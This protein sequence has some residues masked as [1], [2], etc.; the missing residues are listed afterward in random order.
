MIN[1]LFRILVIFLI[2]CFAFTA[3][4]E[5]FTVTSAADSGP[6]TLRDAILKSNAN[7]TGEK[8]FIY[9]NLPN[10]SWNERSI[11]VN[12]HLP[13]IRGGNLVIDGTTQPGTKLG[14]SDAK[15]IIQRS[16]VVDPNDSRYFALRLRQ[17]ND[18]EIYGIALIYDDTPATLNGYAITLEDVRRI[19]IGAPGKGNLI[20]GFMSGITN[21]TTFAE[22]ITIQGNMAGVMEDGISG[23]RCSIELQN[24]N[25]I[26]LGGTGAGEG[27]HLGMTNVMFAT[28]GGSMIIKG[29][30]MGVTHSGDR[31]IDACNLSLSG[32]AAETILT[33]NHI[34]NGGI[35]LYNL[36]HAF[37]VRHNKIGTDASGTQQL[38][39]GPKY[40]GIRVASCKEGSI[41]ENIITGYIFAGVN[42]SES[43][44]V[45]VSRNEM[46]CNQTGIFLTWY[47]DQAGRPK[48]FADIV[49]CDAG[50]TYGIATPNSKLEIFEPDYCGWI[51]GG[52]TCQGRKYLATITVDA[53]GKWLYPSPPAKGIIVTAT[54]Q[55]G[56]T[57]EYSLA[58]IDY[59]EGYKVVQPTCGMANGSIKMKV[60]RGIIIGWKDKDGKLISTDTSLYNLSPADYTFYISSSGCSNETCINGYWFRLEDI[61]PAIDSRNVIITNASCNH[62]NGEITNLSFNGATENTSY[63]WR[64]EQGEIVG[65]GQGLTARPGKYTL[66]MS[67]KEGSCIATSGPFEIKNT[68]GPYMDLNSVIITNASCGKANGSISGIQVHATGAINYKWVNRE[69]VIVSST[70][71]LQGISAG[72]YLLKYSD[73]SGCPEAETDSFTISDQGAITISTMH[74]T[75]TPAGCT[76]G[77]GAIKGIETTGATSF[78]WLNESGQSAGN[79]PD[80]SNAAPGKYRLLLENMDGCSASTDFIEIKRQQPVALQIQ[81]MTTSPAYCNEDNGAIS[82]LSITGGTP[83]SY[84]WMNENNQLA[85]ILERPT[86]LA[87]GAYQLYVTD[88]NGCEKYLLTAAITKVPPPAIISRNQKITPDEC[89]F[90]TGAISGIT[91]TGEAPFNYTWYSNNTIKGQHLALTG[92]TAGEY[93]LQVTDKYGCKVQSSG[94][95]VNNID[96]PL[97]APFPQSVSIVKGMPATIAVAVPQTGTYYLYSQPGSSPLQSNT[98]GIFHIENITKNTSFYISLQSGSCISP[99]AE[100]PVKV[101]DE[102]KIIAPNAFSPNNDGTNDRFRIRALGLARLEYFAVYNRWGAP[103]FS[104]TNPEA[105]WDGQLNNTPQPAGTYVWIVKGKDIL[106]EN[107]QYSGHVLLIR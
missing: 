19:K 76:V 86:G 55:G 53:A 63:S 5:T 59:E 58:E 44:A 8:D 70:L 97:Q 6:G 69:G 61:T 20:Y 38:Q 21:G 92:I 11:S 84:R 100:V 60:K 71:D 99:L 79:T 54:D 35:Y 7:G 46:F 9:F 105:G 12:S 89:N 28:T 78:K 57:S 40:T 42:L 48:P 75:V 82:E 52:I 41:T 32:N 24:I 2:L 96:V 64:N 27:N 65:D 88:I 106:G 51:D 15:V 37:T 93:Y 3:D 47:E 90:S 25:G 68:T 102:I 39:T 72:K 49:H 18:V 62:N 66:T 29:N 91:V 33:D 22:N 107:V 43:Y 30:K 80:L 56:A 31:E 94:Y 87:P 67:I 101:V 98:T 34:G 13:E 83:V 103:V 74:M 4:A 10:A 23:N 50:G 45:T 104:T 17:A 16:D 14:L 81:V 77:N 36:T 1:L 95:T 73:E 26:V 85:S